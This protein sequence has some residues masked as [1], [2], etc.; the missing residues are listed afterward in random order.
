M[1]VS[2]LI[3]TVEG[4]VTHVCSYSV[5]YENLVVTIKENATN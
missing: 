2:N 1:A 5:V 4:W 3:P